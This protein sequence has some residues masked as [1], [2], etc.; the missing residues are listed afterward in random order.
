M[1]VLAIALGAL[2]VSSSIIV[3]SACAFGAMQAENPE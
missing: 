2:G 3:W 1:T